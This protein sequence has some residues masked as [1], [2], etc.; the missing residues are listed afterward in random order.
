MKNNKGSFTVEASLVFSVVF[1]MLAAFVY[2]FIIMYQYVNV[3]SIANEAA[4]KGA[5]FYVN[6]TGD[7]YGSNKLNEMYWRIYDTNKNKK[8]V[9][10]NNYVNKL[11]S[12]SVFPAENN[13]SSN[14]YNKILIKNL[15]IEILE[16]YSLPISN[17]FGIFGLSSVLS[18]KAVTNSPLDDNS[19]F[20]RNMDI[21][22]DI[23]NCIKN[24]DTKWTGEGS[25]LENILEKLLKKN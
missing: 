8:I 2:L 6:Q 17:M 16:E 23:R 22:T 20:I 25:K 3:Q 11:L 10:I 4:T 12:K 7:N 19:E 1:F 13:I 21:V 9:G 18:L 14:L 15:K 5:Y 24:S